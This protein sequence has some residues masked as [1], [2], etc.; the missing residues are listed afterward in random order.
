MWARQEFCG[1]IGDH[2]CLLLGQCFHRS[3]ALLV[4]T[5]PNR[6]CQRSVNIVR[7]CCQRCSPKATK[8]V[9]DKRL[10]E[11][12]NIHTG[13]ETCSGRECAGL[14]AK[15]LC[16]PNHKIQFLCR[17]VRFRWLCFPDWPCWATG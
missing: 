1:E 5:I 9:V 16:R 4:N 15:G 8:E 10:P 11:I 2:A 3:H 13:P 12:G 17:G 14:Q 7:C 6:E